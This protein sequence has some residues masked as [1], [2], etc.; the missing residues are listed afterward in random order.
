MTHAVAAFVVGRA[1]AGGGVGDEFDGEHAALQTFHE[2]FEVGDAGGEDAEVH[3]ELG[4]EEEAVVVE[5]WV[6][7]VE[8]LGQE[9]ESVDRCG[10]DTVTC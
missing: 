8:G 7:G 5:G 3:F 10:D 9:Y 1:G 6:G 2:G 4:A